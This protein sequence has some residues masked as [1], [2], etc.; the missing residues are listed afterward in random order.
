M[1]RS[2]NLEVDEP[3]VKLSS[4]GIVEYRNEVEDM[5]RKPL[6]GQILL[7][8]WAIQGGLLGMSFYSIFSTFS[9]DMPSSERR[10]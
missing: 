3:I 9:L 10:F 2:Y 7:C 4:Q 6:T 5:P 8:F 1:C